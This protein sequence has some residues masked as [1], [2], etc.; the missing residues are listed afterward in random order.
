MLQGKG[1]KNGQT[2][3][4]VHFTNMSV[5]VYYI[6]FRIFLKLLTDYQFNFFERVETLPKTIKSCIETI[7]F[8]DGCAVH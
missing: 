1:Q 5:Q 8:D 6:A 4:C 7:L 2:D 3:N